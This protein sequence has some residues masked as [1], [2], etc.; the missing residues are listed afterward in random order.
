MLT[1]CSTGERVTK[2]RLCVPC[3]M[4]PARLPCQTPSPELTPSQPSAERRLALELR[5]HV[6]D[7]V[8][9]FSRA[10]WTLKEPSIWAHSARCEE[11]AHMLGSFSVQA[12][13]EKR[14]TPSRDVPAHSSA[15]RRSAEG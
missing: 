3:L 14:Y 10:A 4:H 11:C 1:R 6:S 7:G 15:S 8:Y 5:W 2:S 13:R 9:I 12:A